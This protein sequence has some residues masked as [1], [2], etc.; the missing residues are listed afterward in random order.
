MTDATD[1]TPAHIC[2]ICGKS[3]P[4]S[5]LRA[6]SAVRPGVVDLMRRAHPGLSADDRLCRND[7]TRYRRD[8]LEDLLEEERGELSELDREVIDSLETGEILAQNPEEEID[9]K[10]TFGQRMA[11]RVATFGGSWT[12]IISFMVILLGWITLNSAS[13]LA[14]PFDPYPYILLNLVL[15]CIAAV[16]APIIMMSQKRQEQKDRLRSENDYQVNLKAELEIRQLHERL[17][18]QMNRQWEKLAELQRLQIEYIE[19]FSDE[20]PERPAPKG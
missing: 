16:Q 1:E 19:T 13:L 12:F 14:R 7:L 6:V 18:Y 4:D 11:D 2:A 3:F 9:E 8:Y 20:G 10:T 5:E 17:D 15:S